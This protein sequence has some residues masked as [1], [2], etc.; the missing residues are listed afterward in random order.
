M[1]VRTTDLDKLDQVVALVDDWVAAL[2]A[3]GIDMMG[4]RFQIR[5]NYYSNELS[6]NKDALPD[7]YWDIV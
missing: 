5:D 7:P 2:D 4:V 1:T 6:Y 3:I